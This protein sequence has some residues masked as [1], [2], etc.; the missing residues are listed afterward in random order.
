MLKTT[1]NKGKQSGGKAFWNSLMKSIKREWSKGLRGEGL[2]TWENSYRREFHSGET[3]W[4]FHTR[5]II[6]KRG[7]FTRLHVPPRQSMSHVSTPSRID[8]NYARVTRSG[9]PTSRFFT[10]RSDFSSC[11][12]HCCAT[13][14][15]NK[16]WS[17]KRMKS[18]PGTAA[19]LSLGRPVWFVPRDDFS[20]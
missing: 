5:M 14:H 13:L 3:T 11:T 2:L 12:W 7:C 1:V 20:W 6:Y 8:K 16:T 17:R 19:G 18:V 15:R 9:L 10:K 4:Y